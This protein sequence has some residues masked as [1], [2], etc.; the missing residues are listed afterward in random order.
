MSGMKLLS[1]LSLDQIGHAPSGPERSPVA[2]RFGTFFQTLAQLVQLSRLQT[3]LATGACGLG[4][5]LGALLLPGLMPAADRLA[6]NAQSSGHFSLMNAPVKQLGGF[7][8]S[9]FQLIKIA[10]DAFWI[11]HA[12]KAIKSNQTC[13]YIM[14][15]SVRQILILLT[16]GL[17][18]LNTFAAEALDRPLH[19]L[20]LGPVN[21]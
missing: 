3:G 17:M 4:E 15:D 7:E 14:R 1:R 20:Y 8:S 2:Q 12:E 21:V 6:M 16:G 19:V 11:A 13:H 18:A 10:L 5:R 9:P